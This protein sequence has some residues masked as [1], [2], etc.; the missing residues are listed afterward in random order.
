MLRS[1][2]VASRISVHSKRFFRVVLEAIDA[3][4]DSPDSFAIKLSMKTHT[5]LPRVRQLV[6]RLPCTIKQGLSVDQANRLKVV[7]EQLNGRAR[8]ESYLETPGV[9]K[10]ASTQPAV[11]LGEDAEEVVVEL[12]NCVSCG[13]A[14]DEGAESCSFC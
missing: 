3:D 13:T 11:H 2:D 4:R 5:S 1:K 9:D 8:L 6:R 12:R 10:P 14:L 7:L